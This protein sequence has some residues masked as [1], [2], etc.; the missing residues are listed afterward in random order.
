MTNDPDDRRQW[1]QPSWDPTSAGEQDQQP[2]PELQFHGQASV[3]GSL[4]PLAEAKPPTLFESGLRV[5]AG[6][7]WPVAIALAILGYGNWILNLA[8]AFVV[9]AVSSSTATEMRR[10]RKHRRG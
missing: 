4:L 7:T 6:I 10:R 3:G 8:V 1:Q 2:E 9:T 5:A